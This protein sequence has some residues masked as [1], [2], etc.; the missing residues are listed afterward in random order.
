[1]WFAAM[2]EEHGLV[3]SSAHGKQGF[4]EPDFGPGLSPLPIMKDGREAVDSTSLECFSGLRCDTS[5]LDM[6]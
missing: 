4:I 2:Q 1:V 5:R 3:A 6:L